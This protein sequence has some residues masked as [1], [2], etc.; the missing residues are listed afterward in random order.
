MIK[1]KIN[2]RRKDET[3]NSQ[4]NKTIRRSNPLQ[5]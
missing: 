1:M 3:P 2:M 4:L 5:I